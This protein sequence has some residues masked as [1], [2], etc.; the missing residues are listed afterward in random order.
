MLWALPHLHHLLLAQLGLPVGA[1]R[2]QDDAVLPAAQRGHL[3]H[4]HHLLRHRRDVRLPLRQRDEPLLARPP[5]AAAGV[6]EGPQ[7]ANVQRFLRTDAG[8]LFQL[9]S[10][11]KLQLNVLQLLNLRLG[12]LSAADTFNCCNF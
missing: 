1:H 3:H 11:A 2:V 8:R 10:E 12:Q 7:G 9:N 5:L 6:L 4:P